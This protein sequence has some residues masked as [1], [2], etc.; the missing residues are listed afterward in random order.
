MP[1]E[2][3]RYTWQEYRS[4]PEDERWELLNGEAFAMSPTPTVRHQT[5]LAQLSFQM[6]PCFKGTPCRVFI[7]PLDVRLDDEN[8][9][10]PD[11]FVVCDPRK[12]QR[13]HVD[14]A[15]DLA[16]EILSPGHESRDRVRKMRIYAR[17]GVK[18]VWLITPQP[19][20]FEVFTLDGATYRLA[21]S[22]TKQDRAT[23]PGF[24]ALDLNLPAL[25]D[26]PPEPGDAVEAVK[27]PPAS[28]APA[29][30]P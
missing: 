20:M 23:S 12:I 14:G 7:A 6:L 29:R 4:W 30:T 15:P 26:F 2:K 17:F 22:Y 27:E 3:R 25:F 10:E 8:C 5:I 16:V 24:P 1:A 19:A 11:L 21:G 18:E 28:Y 13:T 9:V